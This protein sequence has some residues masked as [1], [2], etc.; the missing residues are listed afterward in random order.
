MSYR[1]NL[2]SQICN[3]QELIEKCQR[4]SQIT[5]V[6]LQDIYEQC[7]AYISDRDAI[8]VLSQC[9]EQADKVYYHH[10]TG[11]PL[12]TRTATEWAKYF[13]EGEADQQ[14]CEALEAAQFHH[15]AYG[16]D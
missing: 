10:T 8:D 12:P 11:A 4:G 13:A 5:L 3:T 2:Q 6:Q 7:G 15:D 16:D 9:N 14:R 1:Q